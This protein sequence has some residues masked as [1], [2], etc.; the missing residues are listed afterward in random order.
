MVP[1][2]I[3]RHLRRLLIKEIR[4]CLLKLDA[5]F[6]VVAVVGDRE[7]YGC[8]GLEPGA[9]ARERL[10]LLHGI[11]L[12]AP[13]QWPMVDLGDGVHVD[14][15][16]QPDG[17]G[18][19]DLLLT[20]VS[21]EHAERQAAQQ[22][23]NEVAL[24]NRRLRRTLSQLEEARGELEQKNRALDELN[25]L[26][27][28]FIA[29]L[30]HELRTP[31]T[32]ILGHVELLRDRLSVPERE[33]AIASLKAIEAGSGHLMSLVNNIL[34]HASIET[35][36]LALNPAPTDLGALLGN[37]AEMLRPMAVQSGLEFRYRQPDDLPPWVET[38]ATRLRQAIINLA[39]N[40]IKY[41]PSGFVEL[42]AVW[43]DDSLD[44]RVL[45]S[46]PGI[47]PALRARIFLPFQRGDNVAGRHGVGLGLAISLQLVR[48]MG[49]ELE[50]EDRKGGGSVF[51]FRIPAP[52]IGADTAAAFRQSAGTADEGAQQRVLLIDD[53]CEIRLLYANIL[54][55][56]G[57]FVDQA[58]DEE[59]ALEAFDA[60]RPDIII[61]DLHLGMHESGGLIRRLREKGHRGCIAA[62]SASSLRED[63]ERLLAAGAD[64]YLV[65]P[66]PP[67]VLRQTLRELS[68]RRK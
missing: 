12:C 64:A 60:V 4:P 55:S 17:A 34:D 63:R 26:K 2:S 21:R 7:R 13:Q 25:Q 8:K 15:L 67:A 22:H 36:Q 9:D 53:A 1:M 41:T 56:M 23:A 39:S 44:I 5:A 14:V 32:S 65:K 28:R 58:A 20:D 62:W 42:T 61:V 38:D 59:S 27:S 57:Y 16:L 40:A 3:A 50:L 43:R 11:A 47:P 33:P 46:G 54:E 24:L 18:G 10:A 68:V 48:L 45:D 35:G 52:T 37:L 66:V 31:L 51:G 29:S 6:R 30:S 19:A 49:G